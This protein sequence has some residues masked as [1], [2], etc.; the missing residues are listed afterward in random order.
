MTLHA[1]IHC[2]S[3]TNCVNQ[4]GQH[5]WHDYLHN[6]RRSSL[7]QHANQWFLL[8]V[9]GNRLHSCFINNS[10]NNILFDQCVLS[11]HFIWFTHVD[12][13]SITTTVLFVPCSRFCYL[14][15]VP[16][17]HKQ[18]QS[19]HHD[20]SPHIYIPALLPLLLVVLALAFVHVTQGWIFRYLSAIPYCCR[21]CLGLAEARCNSLSFI[22]YIIT[23]SIQDKDLILTK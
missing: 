14:K 11:N 15:Y 9:N 4:Q 8:R 19:T 22:C 2:F 10:L 13:C 6:Y 16:S 23:A 1:Y 7:S 17:E 18:N 3:H 21:A 5:E 12:T 20:I